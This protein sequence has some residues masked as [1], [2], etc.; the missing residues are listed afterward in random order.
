[1]IVVTGGAGY[2]GAPLCTD[3]AAGG[4]PV[5]ALDSLLTDFSLRRHLAAEGRRTVC[6]QYSLQVHAPRLASVLRE[7]A[8]SQ[9]S[10]ERCRIH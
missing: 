7:A 1:M 5:R 2:I 9:P 6:R 10:K 8:A 4:E 3:L